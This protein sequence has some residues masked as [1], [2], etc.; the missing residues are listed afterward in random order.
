MGW[1]K[2]DIVSYLGRPKSRIMPDPI[3]HPE[4]LTHQEDTGFRLS[5][6]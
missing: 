3:R 4:G 1:I 6:A 5:R 2:N